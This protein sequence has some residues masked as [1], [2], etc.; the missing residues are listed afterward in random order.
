MGQIATSNRQITLYCIEN[1]SVA[2]QTLAYAKAESLSVL[3]VDISKTPITGTQILEMAKGLGMEIKDL[4]DR[5][6]HLF[7]SKNESPN[8]SSDDWITMIQQY[9]EILKQPI[10]IKGDHTILVATPTDII[11]L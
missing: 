6:N 10:A 5:D 8:L 1:S 3:I 7:N 2:K 9:P 4:I 11:K